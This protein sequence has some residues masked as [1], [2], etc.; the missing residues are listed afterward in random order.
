MVT[1]QVGLNE[2]IVSEVRETKEE[3]AF[4]WELT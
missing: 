3:T 4:V 2:G 1:V